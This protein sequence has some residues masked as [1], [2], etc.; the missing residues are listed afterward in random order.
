MSMDGAT[1][2]EGKGS[3]IAQLGQQGAQIGNHLAPLV[4]D[5]CQ[6]RVDIPRCGELCG[7]V[8]SVLQW[9]VL[10]VFNI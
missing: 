9:I 6:A 8:F 7:V 1:W 5:F 3:T 4:L 2:E 10:I